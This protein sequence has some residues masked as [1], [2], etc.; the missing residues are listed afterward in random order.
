[1]ENF[2]DLFNEDEVDR[3]L[4]KSGKQFNKN[5]TVDFNRKEI[6]DRVKILDYPS[7]TYENGK[8]LCHDS[9]YDYYIVIADK[10]NNSTISTH[11]VTYRQD[12]LIANPKTN[13]IFRI[14]TKH[15]KLL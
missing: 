8:Y 2:D 14:A 13:E 7:A 4:S 6:G 1:M 9:L 12:L 15:V 11:G 3:I 10:Q 5:I